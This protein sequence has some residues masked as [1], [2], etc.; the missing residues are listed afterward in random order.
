MEQPGRR[1]RGSVENS[2]GR[3]AATF[4]AG[5]RWSWPR[6]LAIRQASSRTWLARRHARCCRWKQ[7]S[8]LLASTWPRPCMAAVR[9]TKG[10]A[11][12]CSGTSASRTVRTMLLAQGACSGR[13]VGASG[14]LVIIAMALPRPLSP[15]SCTSLGRRHGRDT[16]AA[17]RPSPSHATL[18]WTC[19]IGPTESTARPTALER[20]RAARPRAGL[21]R[22]TLSSR[23]AVTAGRR[24]AWIRNLARRSIIL[25]GIVVFAVVAGVRPWTA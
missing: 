12:P 5:L 13:P 22:L 15:K 10:Q 7:A 19:L 18:A 2:G 11:V 16:A 1:R 6:C 8:E 20:S 9:S 14:R 3:H 4:G 21:A 17:K 24:M 23:G 25:S